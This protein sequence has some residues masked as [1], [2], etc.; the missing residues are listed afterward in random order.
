VEK[1]PNKNRINKH[2]SQQP[3]QRIWA[4]GLMENWFCIWEFSDN[5]KINL[6]LE[7]KPAVVP[8]RYAQ[9]EN[10]NLKNEHP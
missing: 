3:L 2:Y 8:E 9:F 1:L 4:L 6:N 10:K 7:P 5:R